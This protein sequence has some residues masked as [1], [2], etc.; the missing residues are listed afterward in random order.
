[1]LAELGKS[2]NHANRTKPLKRFPDFKMHIN[3]E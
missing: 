3:P 1:M 2:R